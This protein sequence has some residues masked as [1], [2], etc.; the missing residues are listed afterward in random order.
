LCENLI[1]SATDFDMIDKFIKVSDE[2]SA[3]AAREILKKEGLF[4]GIH[5]EQ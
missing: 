3:Y 4:V 2:E 5:Q 1:P